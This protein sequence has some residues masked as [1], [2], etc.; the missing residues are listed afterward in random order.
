MSGSESDPINLDVLGDN[1]SSFYQAIDNSEQRQDDE[2]KDS[3]TL[4]F[5]GT[6]YYLCIYLLIIKYL[7]NTNSYLVTFTL[8]FY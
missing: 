8:Y 3:Q 4:T 7:I 6:E 1:K 5:V 2:S